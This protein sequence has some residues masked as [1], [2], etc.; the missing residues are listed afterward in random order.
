MADSRENFNVRETEGLKPQLRDGLHFSIR[1]ERDGPICLIEDS[2]GARFHRV[3]IIEYRF[4]RGLDGTRTVATLLAELARTGGEDALTEHEALQVIDWARQQHLLSL[5]S[6]RTGSAKEEDEQM[7]RRA[8]TWLNPLIVRVPLGRPDAIFARLAPRL[9]WIFGWGGA[10]LW[11]LT[12][13]AAAAHLGPEWR[14]FM[15]G[16]DGILSRDNWLYIFIAFAGLKLVHEF[17]HGLWCR[18]FG[19]PVREVGVMFILGLPMGYVDATASI[20][21]DSK[22]RRIMVASAGL[23]IEFFLAAVAAIVWSYAGPGRLEDF[24]HTIVFF[25]TAVTLFF[26]ANPLMR[27]DGYFIL[28]DLL[29]VPNLATR[30]RHWV[31]RAVGWLLVGAKELKPSAPRSREQWT[32]AIYGV[33][34]WLWQFL[35][36][37]GL[38]AGATSLLRGGGLALAALAV[39]AWIGLPFWQFMTRLGKSLPGNGGAVLLRVA[40]AILLVLSVGFVRFHRVVSADG[41]LEYADTQILRVECPGF[42]EKV[43]VEDGAEVVEGQELVQ[44]RNPEAESAV[45]RARLALEQEESRA[46]IAYA[47]ED[48]STF[49]ALQAKVA[50]RR[51]TLRQNEKYVQTMTIRAPISGRIAA[52]RLH[53]VQGAFLPRGEEVLRIGRAKETDVKVAVTEEKEA[54]FR[55]ALEGPVRVRVDGRN[56]TLGGTLTRMEARAGREIVLPA[57]TALA[58]GPL[59]VR[60]VEQTRS[61]EPSYE[62]M[63]ACFLATVRL[64][65]KSPLFPGETATV[66]LT[67][68]ISVTPWEEIQRLVDRWW[69]R[70]ITKRAEASA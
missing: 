58:G 36:L 49:Q 42:V 1:E 18:H 38:I 61:G 2:S 22:W 47:R 59:G 7:F 52:R 51:E 21:L 67:S 11:A 24:A 5:D 30:G 19:A 31:Q 60:R 26:N 13:I 43:N 65:E 70:A 62:L 8:A 66:K 57:L 20:G 16:F 3:G 48:V 41:V 54:H 39:V 33:A 32:V 53:E 27:F 6:G 64:K 37:G 40:L 9:S 23:W 69:R 10:V 28:A 55:A 17:S 63:D 25:G 44:L 56:V 50:S 14:R 4:L 68:R 15:R 35:V 45:V 34:A 29:E 12:L 46:R